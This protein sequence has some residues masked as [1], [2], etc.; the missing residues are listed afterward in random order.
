MAVVTSGIPCDVF[1]V[2]Q[3]IPREWGRAKG[4]RTCNQTCPAGTW[5]G[6]EREVLQE[7]GVVPAGGRLLGTAG[8]DVIGHQT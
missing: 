3:S 8:E 4:S 6:N 5:C 2:E 1:G 7:V